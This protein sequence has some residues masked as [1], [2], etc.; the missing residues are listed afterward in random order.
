MIESPA[1]AA[2]AD[3]TVGGSVPPFVRPAGLHAWNRYAA[4]NHEFV[5]IHMDDAAGR[6]AGMPG[7]IGMGN[8]VVGWLHAAVESW[9]DGRGRLERLDVRFR[10][11]ALRGDTITCRGTITGWN[12]AED[13]DLLL[14]L[15]LW[16]ENQSGDKIAPASARVRVAAEQDR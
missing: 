13:G 11:P 2:D 10:A 12:P 7:A 9:L 3:F 6:A 14:E 8:L 5:D 16:A 1:T 15:D 4:V